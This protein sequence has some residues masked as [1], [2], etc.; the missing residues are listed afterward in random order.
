MDAQPVNAIHQGLISGLPVRTG[1]L[2]FTSNGGKTAGPGQ[3]WWLIGLLIPG[4]VDHVA[5]YTG[6]GGRCVEAGAL[7]RVVAFEA[8]E[9]PWN[10]DAMYQARGFIDRL[11]GVGDPLSGRGLPPEE[12]TRIRLAAAEFCLEQVRREAPYNLNF[13]DSDNPDS[14]YCS[15]LAYAA[16]LPHGVNLNLGRQML[17][18]PATRR[19]VFPQEVWE[20]CAQRRRA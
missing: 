10:G 5:V 7:G 4:E 1:D 18:L 15:Q 3:F 13:L 20:A 2:L 16:Y 8:P 12:E 17:G 19:I 14:F 9:S 11:Y 6:P